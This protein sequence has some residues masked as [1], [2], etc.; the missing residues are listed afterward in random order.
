MVAFRAINHQSSASSLCK[1]VSI[2]LG[3]IILRSVSWSQEFD[4][5]DN[6]DGQYFVAPLD[7]IYLFLVQ[8]VCSGDSRC[9]VDMKDSK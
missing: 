2:E 9:W 5:G 1:K 3:I 8:T 7:G 4:Y 6:F